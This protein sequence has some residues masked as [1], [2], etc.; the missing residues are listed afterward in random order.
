MTLR[1]GGRH[2]ERCD[3]VVVDLTGVSSGRAERL[4]RAADRGQ[5]VCVRMNVDGED[6]PIF[7]AEPSPHWTGGVLLVAA[8]TAGGCSTGSTDEAPK[9]A[10]AQAV[11]GPAMVPIDPASMAPC[12]LEPQLV[13]GPVPAVVLA[14]ATD[15]SPVPTPEQRMLTDDKHRPRIRMGRVASHF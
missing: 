5:G 10:I 4:V 7:R 6:A 12:D 9:A 2:C 1:A 8:L 13:T 14:D 11:D 3:H 15:D